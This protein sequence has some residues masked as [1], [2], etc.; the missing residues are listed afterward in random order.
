MCPRVICFTF[1]KRDHGQLTSHSKM[2]L[3]HY[4][5]VLKKGI[6]PEMKADAVTE[7]VVLERLN[8]LNDEH[9]KNRDHLQVL[10]IGKRKTE[11]M[12]YL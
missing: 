7:F 11:K 10:K 5:F 1:M 8:L 9:I 6:S 4:H 2:K 12:Y 3:L